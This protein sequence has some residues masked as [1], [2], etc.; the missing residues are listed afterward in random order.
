VYNW[1]LE[2]HTISLFI[3]ANGVGY[4]YEGL[5]TDRFLTSYLS[6]DTRVLG[7][8]EEPE[9]LEEVTMNDV[10]GGGSDAYDY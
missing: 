10:F 4:Y 3:D 8:Y 6:S 7:I 5:S 2:N 1:L 9:P